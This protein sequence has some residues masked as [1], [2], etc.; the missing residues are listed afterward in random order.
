[1]ILI[2]VWIAQGLHEMHHT[3]K[4]LVRRKIYPGL[5][6]SMAFVSVMSFKLFPLWHDVLFSQRGFLFTAY[7]AL[8]PIIFLIYFIEDKIWYG[9]AK[10]LFVSHR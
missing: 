1:M 7:Y 8:L 4:T 6:S 10:S 3:A 9:K 5:F 2:M